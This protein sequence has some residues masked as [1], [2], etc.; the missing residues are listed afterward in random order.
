MAV[1]ALDPEFARQVVAH[2]NEDHGDAVLLYVQ[3]LAGKP[4]ARKASL[5]SIDLDKMVI[6]TDL[7]S[8]DEQVTVPLTPRPE[9]ADYIRAALISMAKRAR[10]A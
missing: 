6:A 8:P 1:E 7:A 5:E 4:D 10:Q 9:S 2:M 3:V